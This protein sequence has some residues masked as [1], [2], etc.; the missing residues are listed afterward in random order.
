MIGDAKTPKQGKRKSKLTAPSAQVPAT[1]FSSLEPTGQLANPTGLGGR[2]GGDLDNQYGA[3]LNSFGYNPQPLVDKNWCTDA[4]S[5]D[6]KPAAI[7]HNALPDTSQYF[8]A[9]D[10]NEQFQ[11]FLNLSKTLLASSCESVSQKGADGSG[12]VAVHHEAKGMDNQLQSL[13]NAL[14]VK[15]QSK[16]LLS[17]SGDASCRS[18]AEDDFQ[19]PD[20]A[21]TVDAFF[22]HLNALANTSQTNQNTLAIDDHCLHNQPESNQQQSLAPTTD[23]LS[24]LKLCSETCGQEPELKSPFVP[25]QDGSTLDQRLIP[26]LV[27]FSLEEWIRGALR[28]RNFDGISSSLYLM[29]AL[30]IAI[31]LTEEV[32]S[33]QKVKHSI[34]DGSDWADRIRIHTICNLQ[35]QEHPHPLQYNVVDPNMHGL[36]YLQTHSVEIQCYEKKERNCT[37]ELD[38]SRAKLNEDRAIY[39][40]GLIFYKLFSGGEFPSS[41]LYALA[42]SDGAF[43]SLSKLNLV[44]QPDN[45]HNIQN[46][47]K[48]HQGSPSLCQMSCE[49]LA[50]IGVP[51][52]LC[53]LILNMIGCVYGKLKG[54]D[55]YSNLNDISSDL[56]LMAEKPSTYLQCVNTDN[57]FSSGL[58]SKNCALSRDEEFAAVKSSYDRCI[59][60]SRELA[61]IKGESGTGKTLLAHR[62][63]MSII[64]DGGIILMGKFDQLQSPTPFSALASAFDMYCDVLINEEGSDWVTAVVNNLR[65]VLNGEACHLEMMIPKLGQILETESDRIATANDQ[66][67]QNITQT[68]LF[69][70]SQFIRVITAHSKSVTL[71]LDDVQWADEASLT[72][73]N[74]LLRHNHKRFFFIGCCRDD[75][76]SDDHQF[77]RLIKDIASFGVCATTV[78]LAC[79]EEDDL[80]EVISEVFCLLPRL[81]K[82]LSAII[83]QKTRGNPL[84]FMQLLLSLYNDGLI[85]LDLRL[86]RY[87]WDT[88]KIASTQLPDDIAMCFTSRIRKLSFEVQ[89]ALHSLALFGSTI[90]KDILLLLET[91][92]NIRLIQH[93]E[94][95]ETKGF[96][97]YTNDSYHFGHDQIQGAFFHLFPPQIRAI[98]QSKYGRCLSEHYEN[99]GETNILFFALSQ[100]NAVAASDIFDTYECLTFANHNLKAGKNAM[101]KVSLPTVNL[102]CSET[103]CH[104]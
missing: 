9:G 15:P 69:L 38:S 75:E 64:E 86:K 13:L 66:N 24:H 63:G 11:A 58:Q 36:D 35:P 54:N 8:Q 14:D 95:A 61:I 50:I 37:L 6:R 25:P 56:N 102:S 29:A 68:N 48:H 52:P 34:L 19:R 23:E 76:M 1:A 42:S 80:N 67:C 85:Q 60:G 16:S 73:I 53:T 78:Q 98:M 94:H 74:G 46:E 89:F 87:V 44:E 101:L 92:L 27:T 22:P 91:S 33:I 70:L 79:I 65:A 84:F 18:R 51:G 43:V 77:W 4:Y 21:A 62:V 31:L 83:H 104:F 99:T 81:V 2:T 103:C 55:C 3:I 72:I 41:S 97:S 40:L 5:D 82:P 17:S 30:K 32:V 88:D 59:H 45:D 47:S 7:I 49:Y 71:C 93:M 12:E 39:Y 96:I 10:I 20:E 26:S 100:I 90:K 57:F 28:T